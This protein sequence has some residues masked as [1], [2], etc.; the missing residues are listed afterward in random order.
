MKSFKVIFVNGGHDIING[1]RIYSNEDSYLIDHTDYPS[2]FYS[3]P[4]A[5]VKCITP[6]DDEE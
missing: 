3:C 4:K 5:S 2:M 6:L 1:S